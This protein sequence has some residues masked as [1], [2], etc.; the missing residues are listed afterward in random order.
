LLHN[1][2]DIRLH[3]ILINATIVYFLADIR[4]ESIYDLLAGIRPPLRG[5]IFNVAPFAHGLNSY[6][7]PGDCDCADCVKLKREVNLA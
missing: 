7:M 5:Q 3:P 2:P 1:R 4:E 6:A